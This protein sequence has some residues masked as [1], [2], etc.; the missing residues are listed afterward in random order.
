MTATGIKVTPEELEQVK[1][2]YETSG[3]WLSGGRPM[4]DPQR[5]VAE[6]ARKYKAP[7]GAGLSM[8]DGQF[9]LP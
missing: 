1:T 8:K 9:Y 3:M 4:G 6:L 5:A 7:D 2:E